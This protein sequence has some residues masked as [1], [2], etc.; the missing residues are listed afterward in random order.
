MSAANGNPS[1]TTMTDATLQVLLEQA[2]SAHCKPAL[3]EPFRA[4]FLASLICEVQAWRGS[5]P[6]F[7]YDDVRMQIVPRG[8]DR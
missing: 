6:Q 5:Y 2:H 1:P 3:C 4:D 7:E 8:I